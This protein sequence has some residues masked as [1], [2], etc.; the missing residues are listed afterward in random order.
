MAILVGI[1]MIAGVSKRIRDT[2]ITLP[3]L[4]VLFGL[5]AAFLLSD[6]IGLTFYDPLI[7]LVAELTLLMVL[8]H[9]CVAY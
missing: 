5:A 6:S 8:A 7:E 3:M 9:G 4:D 2:I 1:V